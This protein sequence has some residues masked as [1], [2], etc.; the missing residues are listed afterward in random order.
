M[1][2][3]YFLMHL[4]DFVSV[5]NINTNVKVALDLCQRNCLFQKFKAKIK[6]LY[7]EYN[8]ARAIKN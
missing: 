7:K 3:Y 2:D 4:D 5:Y 6:F 1:F 8:L